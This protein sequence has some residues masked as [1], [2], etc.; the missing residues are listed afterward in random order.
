M[1]AGVLHNSPST[2]GVDVGKFNV[3]RFLKANELSREQRRAQTPSYV[4]FGGGKHLCP[5]RQLAA[6]YFGLV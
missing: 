6:T 2:W 4:T 5:G 1:P 3:R